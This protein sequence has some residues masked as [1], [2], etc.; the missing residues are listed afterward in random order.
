MGQYFYIVNLT[1]REYIDPHRLDCGLKLIEI[2]ASDLLNVLGLLL[3]QSSETGGGDIQKDYRTAGR[4]AGNRIAI[5]G[6]YD[7]SGIYQRARA[8]FEEISRE[9][10]DDS[11]D[12]VEM[13]AEKLRYKPEGV[14]MRARHEPIFFAC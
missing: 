2:V 3:R 8:G 13:K 11:N 14:V 10:I 12:F 4:W 6:D 9:I 1:K 7:A 5:V